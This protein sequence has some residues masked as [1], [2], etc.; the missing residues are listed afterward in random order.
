M[1]TKSPKRL[2]VFLVLALVAAF[3]LIFGILRGDPLDMRIEASTL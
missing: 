3:A 1:M 2:V